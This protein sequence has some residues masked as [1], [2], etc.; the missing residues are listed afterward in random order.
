M[1]EYSLVS[2]RVKSKLNGIVAVQKDFKKP[3]G[4]SRYTRAW[5][6]TRSSFSSEN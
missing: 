2:G 5:E 4:V 1:I 6:G 3:L